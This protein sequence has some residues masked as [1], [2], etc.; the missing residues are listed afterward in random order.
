MTHDADANAIAMIAFEYW[1]RG[2]KDQSSEDPK[3]R[4]SDQVFDLS[5]E[6]I[7]DEDECDRQGQ[8]R[9]HNVE[10]VALAQHCDDDGL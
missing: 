10:H 8:R 1:P 4:S 5:Q 7:D 3:S 6:R 9:T 2:N